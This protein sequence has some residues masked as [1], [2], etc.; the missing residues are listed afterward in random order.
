MPAARVV[1][2]AAAPLCLAQA[3]YGEGE[4]P[5]ALLRGKVVD[6]QTGEVLPARVYICDSA[7]KWYFARCASPEGSAVP[8]SKRARQNPASVEM[9]TTIS[10]HPFSAELPPGV[11][12]ITVERGKEY[13]PQT[14]R[15]VVG[16]EGASVTIALRRWVNMAQRG[17]YSGDT[18]VH[19][20]LDELPNV[21]LAEDLNVAFPLTYW[22]A[23][24]FVAPPQCSRRP[25]APLAPQPIYV[26]RQHVIYPLNT[27]YEIGTVR[28]RRHTLGAFFVLGQR[29][30]LNDGVPPVSPVARA[31]HEQGALLELDKHAWPWSMALVPTMGVDLYELSNNHVWRTEFGFPRFGEP[32]AEYMQVER[33]ER[34]LTEW[35]WIDYGLKN[36][37]ALVNCGFRLRPTAG[38]ASGVHPVPLGFSRVYVKVEGEFSYEKWFSRLARGQS[39]VTNGPMLLA[40]L[41]DRDPGHVFSLAPGREKTF[42]LAGVALSARPLRAIEVISQ[43]EVLAE[44]KPANRRM[45]SGGYESPFSLVYAT[46]RSTWLA[47]RCFED[48]PDGRVRFAH[49]APFYIDI[50][51][52]PVRPKRCEVEYLIERVKREL[53]RSAGVLPEEALA[54]YRQ[55]LQA[56]ERLAEQAR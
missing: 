15:V 22:V 40:T 36:Y 18:H 9:H 30:A 4:A 38:T 24:A 47:V 21:M 56:Y 54:E 35:G 25:R 10:A 2:L 32:P 5:T 46:G 53:E 43:G 42:R 50:A 20:T 51:G 14:R 7:G 34:G 27:E 28:G 6:G 12:T 26:D 16:A 8:Y 41:D 17:W 19:R 1:A 45:P 39:F 29:A 3:A 13:L 33:D 23:R 48:R 55:A 37:Y 52:Q 44:I 11:Y 49:T 31:A